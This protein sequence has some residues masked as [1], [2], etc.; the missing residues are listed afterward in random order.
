[1]LIF[2]ARDLL[3]CSLPAVLRGGQWLEALRRFDEKSPIALPIPASGLSC[4]TCAI[5]T[6]I[7]RFQSR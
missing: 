3:A 2:V 4:S 7:A 1:M 6:C 5:P